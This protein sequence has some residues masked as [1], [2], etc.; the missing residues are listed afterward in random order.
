MTDKTIAL[1][2]C[3][4]LKERLKTVAAFQGR[5]FLTRIGGLDETY[6]PCADVRPGQERLTP[7]SDFVERH[8][9]EVDVVLM[10]R[11]QPPTTMMATQDALLQA[12]HAAVYADGQTLGGLVRSIRLDGVTWG[13]TEG[14]AGTVTPVTLRWQAVWATPRTTLIQVM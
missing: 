5:V 13:D 8:E 14:I 4:A 10:A 2:V 7:L 3:E 11:E 6:A 1:Q 9:I 12:V